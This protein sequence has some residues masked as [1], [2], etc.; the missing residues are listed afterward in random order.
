M[1][2]AMKTNSISNGTDTEK[3]SEHFGPSLVVFICSS[4]RRK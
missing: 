3:F 2:A 1:P 4:N